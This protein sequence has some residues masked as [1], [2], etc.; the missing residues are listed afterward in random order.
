M[1][2]T[3]GGPCIHCGASSS[4]MWRNN[5]DGQQVCRANNCWREEAWLPEK[6]QRGRRPAAGSTAQQT[7]LGLHSYVASVTKIEGQRCA[8]LRLSLHLHM[9]TCTRLARGP[10]YPFT[11]HLLAR[12]CDPSKL[13]MLH[14]G[15]CI[16][17][18]HD[19][20]SYLVLG[21]FKTSPEHPGFPD[22]RW[23][24]LAELKAS[25]DLQVTDI[26]T[27]LAEYATASKAAADAELDAAPA[28]AVA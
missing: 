20:P 2:I 26:K 24:T 17:A 10:P 7:E 27:K 13:P 8:T 21:I 23:L 4:S 9:R 6:R 18:E 12:F 1:T 16:P 28:P 11:S 19:K 5:P 25:E 3:E 14:A 22:K 15:R